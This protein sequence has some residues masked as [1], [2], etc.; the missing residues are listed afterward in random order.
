MTVCL[1]ERDEKNNN[2]DIKW[3]LNEKQKIRRKK[4]TENEHVKMNSKTEVAGEMKIAK[5]EEC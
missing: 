5:L 4:Q 3:K 1:G 2:K